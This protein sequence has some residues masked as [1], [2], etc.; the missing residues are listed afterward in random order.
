MASCSAGQPGTAKSSAVPMWQKVQ[1]EPQ[2]KLIYVDMN[3]VFQGSG[4]TSFLS[5][6]HL[7][8]FKQKVKYFPT[9]CK[10]CL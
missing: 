6:I 9:S 10:R 4:R 3:S 1:M 7:I 8:V 2:D 5:V